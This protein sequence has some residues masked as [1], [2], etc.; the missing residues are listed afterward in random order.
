MAHVFS[1]GCHCGNLELRFE[2]EIAPERLAVRTCACSFCS[3]HGARAASDPAGR[4]QIVVHDSA[5][6]I[7]YRFALETADFLVC[8]R[9]GIYV[10]AVAGDDLDRHAILNVNVLDDS[11]RFTRAPE[12]VDYSDESESQRR[13]RRAARWTPVVGDVG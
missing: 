3:R 1:G 12:P 10:A 4:M 9:C 8:G 11:E 2:T 6:L 5:K 13:E 7:R